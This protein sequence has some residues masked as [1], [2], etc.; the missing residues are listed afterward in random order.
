MTL[1]SIVTIRILTGF[2]L[3]LRQAAGRDF[4]RARL[5]ADGPTGLRCPAHHL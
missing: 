5:E 1:E 3:S 2:N 4:S